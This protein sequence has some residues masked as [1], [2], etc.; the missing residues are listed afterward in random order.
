MNK[1]KTSSRPAK[2]PRAVHP[3]MRQRQFVYQDDPV[4]LAHR[5]IAIQRPPCHSEDQVKAYLTFKASAARQQQAI[6]CS[7]L[8]A[9]H[10]G[11]RFSR[12]RVSC[13]VSMTRGCCEGY[14]W[15]PMRPLS[16]A[17]RTLCRR[18]SELR[19]PPLPPAR[20]TLHSMVPPLDLS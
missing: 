19:A 1:I 2:S 17:P 15:E 10:A 3:P 4:P 6:R 13:H 11:T 20:R 5:R 14:D 12:F 9:F 7:D 8:F 18:H 16:G